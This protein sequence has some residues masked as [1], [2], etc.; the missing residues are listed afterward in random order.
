MDTTQLAVFGTLAG[1]LL[2]GGLQ[3]LSQRAQR[4]AADAAA[5]RTDQVTAIADLA[6]VLAD[7]RRAMW[8]RED[9]RLRGQDWTAARAESHSTRSAITAPLL[10]VLILLPD[11]AP[12]AHAAVSAVYELRGVADENSLTGAREHAI[13]ASDKFVAAAGA[14]LGR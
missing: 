13:V 12:P 14:L 11:L 10:R 9:L 6:S 8:V 7:H 1:A 2:T 4:T 3:L 5:L